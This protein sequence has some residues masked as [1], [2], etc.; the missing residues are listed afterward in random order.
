MQLSGH[1]CSLDARFVVKTKGDLLGTIS[2]RPSS[3]G[4]GKWSYKG[5]VFNAPFKAVGSG[6][7]RVNL[8]DDRSSGTVDM[9]GKWTIKIPVVGDQTR[10]P[11][12][13]FTLKAARPCTG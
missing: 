5:K 10:S 7:Y 12:I 9:D 8:A 6:S 11:R 13:G 1:A 2:F 3:K 4:R